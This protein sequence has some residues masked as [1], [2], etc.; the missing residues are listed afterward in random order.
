[1]PIVFRIV[2][3]HTTI[4]L[5]YHRRKYIQPG[6]RCS[7][8]FYCEIS[9]TLNLKYNV[10]CSIF[11]YIDLWFRSYIIC[12]PFLYVFALYIICLW[13]NLNIIHFVKRIFF[14]KTLNTN[15]E[16]QILWEFEFWHRSIYSFCVL[17]P[18]VFFS[19]LYR[20]YI[21]NI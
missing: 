8:I 3:N 5:I 13:S 20:K 16:I 21:H 4:N 10:E 7:L 17:L 9:S 18:Y 1:M 2:F 15:N 19:C 12:I 6:Y 14:Y 11:H